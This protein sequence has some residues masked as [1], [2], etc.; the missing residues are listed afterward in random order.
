MTRRIP[1]M[2]ALMAFDAAARHQS[3]TRAAQELSLTEGA[4]SRQ[5]A[6]LEGTLGV[7]L[8]DRVKKRVVLTQTGQVY[9]EQVRQ[10][11]A[12]IER[13]AMR[14][15]AHENQGGVIELAVL[16]TFASQWLMPRLAGFIR[17]H[18]EITINMS[19]RT[20][21]FLFQGT[22]FDAAIHFGDPTW[23]GTQAHVLFG[24]E[25]VPVCRPGLIRRRGS[26]HPDARALAKHPL[27]HNATRPADWRHWFAAAGVNDVKAMKG[28]RFELHSLL[29]SAACAGLG[30][31]LLPRFLVA[32]QV[33]ARMLEIPVDL[34]LRSSKAYYLVCPEDRQASPALVLFREW[35][36]AEARQFE[37]CIEV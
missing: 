7:P 16:P 29:I 20:G 4:V 8:F 34:A 37:S 1:S 24:E 15:M 5:V 35:L 10:S 19:V 32:E 6:A 13:D 26:R 36:Q 2:K 31:A 21:V 12:L 9:A 3:F 27:L 18:P 33:Q 17:R 30:I 14:I 25:T 28:A 23:P 22:S 11:L